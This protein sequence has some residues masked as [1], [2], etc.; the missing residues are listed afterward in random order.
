MVANIKIVP[1]IITMIIIS[2]TVVL[3]D[4]IQWN[5]CP[6]KEG[7]T[8]KRITDGKTGKVMSIDGPAFTSN[9]HISVLFEDGT[10]SNPGY[11]TVWDS[12]PYGDINWKYEKLNSQE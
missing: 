10:L 8:V 3:I 4:Q 11:A 9:C 12:H 2:V 5:D 7:D 1:A 6:I